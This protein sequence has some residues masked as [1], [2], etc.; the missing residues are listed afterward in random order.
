M[1]TYPP[2][3]AGQRVLAATLAA[4]IPNVVT[5][6]STQTVN[7]STA[8]VNDD[9]LFAAVE[10]GGVYEVTAW[11]V[12]SSQTAGD[13]ALG[14]SAPSGSTMTWGVQGPAASATAASD[15]TANFQ[16]RS[17]SQTAGMGGGAGTAVCTDARGVLTVGSTAG[18]LR[19]RWAQNVANASDTQVLSGS[20]LRVKRVA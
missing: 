2:I 3:Y 11:I 4:M 5:K 18:L 1:A 8:L 20:Q 10:A 15:G 6:G 14:W 12:H 9:T 13:I 7:N 19:L 16:Q 17:L